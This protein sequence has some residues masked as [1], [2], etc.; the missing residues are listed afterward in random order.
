MKSWEEVL[1]ESEL[2][3]RKWFVKNFAGLISEC[4]KGPDYQND[5]LINFEANLCKAWQA[6]YTYRAE[7]SRPGK[8]WVGQMDCGY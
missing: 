3:F 2:E 4:I 7:L 5:W 6:G 1:K 8:V